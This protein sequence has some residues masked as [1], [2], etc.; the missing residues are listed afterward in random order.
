[1]TI[2]INPRFGVTVSPAKSSGNRR[3]AADGAIFRRDNND[4]VHHV[5]GEGG[6]KTQATNDA[7]AK[8]RAWV[9]EQ[10]E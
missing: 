8:A 7:V 3:Y 4:D 10:A 5:V 2:D 1:V 9:A 6:H